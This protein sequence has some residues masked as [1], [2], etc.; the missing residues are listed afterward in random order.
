M[1]GKTAI[2]WWQ[3]Q[4]R[5]RSNRYFCRS[6]SVPPVRWGERVC[7]ASPTQRLLIISGTRH[8]DS[9]GQRCVGRRVRGEGSKVFHVPQARTHTRRHTHTGAGRC[10]KN[11][12][13]KQLLSVSCKVSLSLISFIPAAAPSSPN[14][15]NTISQVAQVGRGGRGGIICVCVRVCVC[16]CVVSPRWLGSEPVLLVDMHKHSR[17]QRKRL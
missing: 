13:K 4:Q 10:K 6:A 16:V 14:P 3:R 1:R 15:E 17:L 5:P 2:K 8:R 11:K 9:F 7:D 12:T